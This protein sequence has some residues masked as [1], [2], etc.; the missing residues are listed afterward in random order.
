MMTLANAG[1][2]R[3]INPTAVVA[4]NAARRHAMSRI[5]I[6]GASESGSLSRWREKRPM[7]RRLQQAGCYSPRG[8]EIFSVCAQYEHHARYL[9]A[10]AESAARL[11]PPSQAAHAGRTGK[12]QR[13]DQDRH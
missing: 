13:V 9:A 2:A 6:F 5:Y 10:H 12:R 8:E 1:V 4:R 3:A 11:I 7:G